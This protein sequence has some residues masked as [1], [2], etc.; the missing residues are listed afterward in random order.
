MIT[1]NDQR[2]TYVVAAMCSILVSACVAGCHKEV[3]E[4]RRLSNQL[5]H[6]DEIGRLYVDDTIPAGQ[7][8]D[9]HLDK[10]FAEK[11]YFSINEH[12][13]FHVERNTHPPVDP[14]YWEYIDPAYCIDKTVVLDTKSADF[15]AVVSHAGFPDETGNKPESHWHFVWLVHVDVTDSTSTDYRRRYFCGGVVSRPPYT[16]LENLLEDETTLNKIILGIPDAD[17][18]EK[19]ICD[20]FNEPTNLTEYEQPDESTRERSHNGR[21]HGR[22]G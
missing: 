22:G 14:T 17:N 10:L 5:C 20:F 2:L 21:I 8:H 7:G 18:Q 1:S 6:Y 19:D 15:H 3:S 13:R 12:R 4:S 16:Q 9:H 11:L